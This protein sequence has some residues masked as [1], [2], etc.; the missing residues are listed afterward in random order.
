MALSDPFSTTY[1]GSFQAGQSL[2]QGINDAAGTVADAMKKK[3]TFDMMKKFGLIKEET[4]P[5][6]SDELE[7]NL[8]QQGKAMGKN[9]HFNLAPDATDEQKSKFFTNLHQTFGIPIPQG[10]TKTIISPGVSIDEKG[11]SYTAP[12]PQDDLSKELKEQR[13]QSMKDSDELKQ[14]NKQDKLEKDAKQQFIS[15]R[16]DSSIAAIEKQRDAS[17]QGYTTLKDIRKEGR[18]PNSFE[19]QDVLAQTYRSRTGA[20][21]T[22][23]IMKDLFINTLGVQK[24]KVE[25]FFSGKATPATTEDIANKVESFLKKSGTQL[26]KMHDKYMSPRLVK[27]DG[28]SD[29]KWE[30]ISKEGRGMRFSDAVSQYDDAGKGVT[31]AAGLTNKGNITDFSKMTDDQLKAIINGQ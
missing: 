11:A 17:I 3:Q 26:D 10:N 16:G 15:V 12:K 19:L 28:L 31:D 13:L 18:L 7:K 4:T 24:N 5:P 20:A 23:E 8:I 29:K 9:V 2:G 14:Q 30:E 21:P 27:P 1:Q 25:Q 22:N 6:S